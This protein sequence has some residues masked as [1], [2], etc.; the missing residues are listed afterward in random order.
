[1]KNRN[2][3]YFFVTIALLII[4]HTATADKWDNAEKAIKHLSPTIYKG[5]PEG[6]IRKLKQRGCTIPQ[7]FVTTAAHNIISGEF[8]KKGQ[9][10]WA[11]L[12]SLNHSS[13]ILIFW[14]GASSC[15]SEF[16]VSKDRDWLQETANGIA[17]SRAISVVGKAF[18]QSHFE[19]YGGETPPPIE[20]SAIDEAFIEK[21][22]TVHYCHN[23]K[24]LR[25]TGS[26]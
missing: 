10:D 20:H 21:S 25:L 3:F 22:S 24:W 14:G 26:D 6:F 15:Q 8:A 7:S 19:A 2:G 9:Q 4:T 11:I 16:N 5:L 13:T 1:M 17:Y 12:C 23:G 18:I